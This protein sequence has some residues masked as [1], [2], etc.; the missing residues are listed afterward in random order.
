MTCKLSRPSITFP[1]FTQTLSLSNDWYQRLHLSHPTGSIY[2]F[3]LHSSAHVNNSVSQHTMRTIGYILVASLSHLAVQR[4]FETQDPRAGRAC[5][6][7]CFIS[8]C[9]STNEISALKIVHPLPKQPPHRRPRLS[10]QLSST[11]SIP[12][13]ASSCFV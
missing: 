6:K 2:P 8:R 5:H 13:S 1:L 3:N 10:C 4:G 9:T 12:V 7:K 11:T